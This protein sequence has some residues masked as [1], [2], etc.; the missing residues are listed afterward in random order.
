MNPHIRSV[1]V[2]TCVTGLV[3]GL[4][5]C[6]TVVDPEILPQT[7]AT[8]EAA[9]TLLTQ[10]QILIPASCG[11]SPAINCPGGVAGSPVYVT[12]TRTASTVTF[13]PGENRY[14]FSATLSAVTATG[15]PITITSVGECTLNINTA[16]GAS[17]TFT[18]T[19][20][21]RFAGQ[22]VGGPIDRVVVDNIAIAGLEEDDVTI[23]GS[24]GCL[25]ADAVIPFALGSITDT[26]ED[27]LARAYCVAPG[28][29]LLQVCP[30]SA[31]FYGSR[32]RAPTPAPITKQLKFAS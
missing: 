11:G 16:A 4:Y 22:F 3:S 10:G 25:A 13:V 27:D 12:L 20:S 31:N 19:G 30:A 9:V 18:V 17:P 26:L 32:Q 29:T 1:L 7:T 8:V 6:K 24:A 23:T 2:T 21:A 5:A 14:D 15:I 28:P